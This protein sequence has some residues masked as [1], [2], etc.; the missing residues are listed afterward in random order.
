M[1][2]NKAKWFWN[3]TKTFGELKQNEKPKQR[4]TSESA[5]VEASY[6]DN[7]CEQKPKS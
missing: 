3:E 7:E 6:I 5:S 1:W 2:N 4:A